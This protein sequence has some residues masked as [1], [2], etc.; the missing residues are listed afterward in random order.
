MTDYLDL[1][2]G[3]RHRLAVLRAIAT[4]HN[5]GDWRTARTT[6]F[7]SWH[8]YEGGLSA[9][10]QPDGAPIWETHQG[11][12]FRNEV[13]A[14]KCD[15]APRHIQRTSGWY[16]DTD[17]ECTM[18]GI[19]ARLPHGRYIAGYYWNRNGERVYFPQVYHCR[20]EAA[21]AADEC[22]RIA[23]ER[24]YADR[25][26][27]ESALRVQDELDSK[28]RRLRECILLRHAV[29]VQYV[30]KEVPG[31]VVAIR[32]ARRQLQ[33]EYADIEF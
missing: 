9:G 7:H 24:E 19:V 20:R 30:R 32:R 12:Y 28:L 21:I 1:A 6:G 33:S 16:T 3:A 5:A 22:A 13:F 2:R 17:T 15:E 14:D 18:R 23:A 26:R 4:K 8:A 10:R 29:A 27:W 11:A 25:V 31:L